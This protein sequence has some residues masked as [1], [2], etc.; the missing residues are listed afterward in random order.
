[1]KPIL[2]A[3][4]LACAC[5]ARAGVGVGVTVRDDTGRLVHLAAPAARV[6][7]LAPDLTELLF[8]V[9]AGDR[10]VGVIARTDFPSAARALPRV[11]TEGSIDPEAVLALAPD[12]VLA[13]PS[14]G[15][16]RTLE[17]LAALGIP[18]FR[19][20]P[21][22]LAGIART[23]EVLGRLTGRVAGAAAAARAFRARL[24]RLERRY[25]GRA[26]V[27]VFYEVWDRPLMTVGARDLITKVIRLCGGDNVFAAL[28]G[29]APQLDREMVLRADPEVIVT[30]GAEG[31]RGAWLEAWRAF[32]SLLAV[33]RDN[34]YFVPPELLQRATPRILEGARRLCEDLDAARARRPAKK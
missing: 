13:L 11:G 4:L 14:A 18:V 28:P 24:A 2:F 29:L 12:L 9:G 30:S 19:S 5:G 33:R 17:R 34:L 20:E 27:G 16:A 31:K 15:D 32:P 3:A 26:K 8:D 10:V 1:M 21:R 7:S 6:V 23:L 25:S 22:E